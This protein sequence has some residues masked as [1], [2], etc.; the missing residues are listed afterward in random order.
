LC[1]YQPLAVEDKGGHSS[2]PH[3]PGP[4]PIPVHS[5][6]TGSLVHYDLCHCG[7]QA[8]SRAYLQQN[9]QSGDVFTTLK[10]GQENCLV[11]GVATALIFGP[12]AQFLG[13]AAVVSHFSIPER[14]VQFYGHLAQAG[15]HPGNVH[16]LP[17]EQCFQG[18]PGLR[19][20]RMKGKCSPFDVDMKC[21]FESF[22]TPG[23]EVAPRSDIVGKDFQGGFFNF[24]YHYSS[25]V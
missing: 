20:F 22:N 1:A 17:G 16:R 13:Q 18:L 23:T 3:L 25:V 5:F 7:V 15:Q 19:R 11:E 24:I 9:R 10:I 21:R 4:L 14:Q 12:L 8:D 6:T 2:Y